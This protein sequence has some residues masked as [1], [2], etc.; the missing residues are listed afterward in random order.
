MIDFDE[1]TEPINIT[2]RIYS[3]NQGYAITP[4]YNLTTEITF[5]YEQG[6]AESTSL[7]MEDIVE[8]FSL[9]YEF[10]CTYFSSSQGDISSCMD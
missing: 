4:V 8:G 6:T 7:L 1:S 3:S 5:S 9:D 10:E 2:V